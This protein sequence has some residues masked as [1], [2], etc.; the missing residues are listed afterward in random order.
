MTRTRYLIGFSL[1]GTI[2]RTFIVFSSWAV[3]LGCRAVPAWH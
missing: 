1:L 2:S 3:A